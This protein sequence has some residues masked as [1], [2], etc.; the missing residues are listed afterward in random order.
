MSLI[1]NIAR[2]TLL[3]ALALGGVVGCS[4]VD[5][6]TGEQTTSNTAKGG[7]VGALGGALFGAMVGGGRGAAIGALAGGAT[8]AVVGNTMDRQNAALRRRLRGTGVLVQR[9]PRGEIRLILASDVTF[10][11]SSANINSGFYP[12]L[13]SI[14]IV[15]RHYD[16]TNIIVSGY[17]SNTGSVGFNQRLSERRAASVGAYLRS[18]GINPNR[19]FTQGYGQ[20]RPVASNATAQGRRANRR[21][22]ITLR[23]QG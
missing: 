4:S 17:T 15:L 19:V 16:N 3:T 21:V 23:R 18:Q 7:A 22:V 6:Y 2:A 14:A 13:D 8:G 9:G 20:R 11:R 10:A 1:K 5:P 12:T